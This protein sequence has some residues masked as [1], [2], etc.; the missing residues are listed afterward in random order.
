MSYRDPYAE[1]YGAGSTQYQNQPQRSDSTSDFNPYSTTKQPHQTYD[2]SGEAA[3]YY[4]NNNNGAYRDD[5]PYD[6]VQ[7]HATQKTYRSAAPAHQD[8]YATVVEPPTFGKEAS[9]FDQGE[10]AGNTNRVPGEKFVF[11]LLPPSGWR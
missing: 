9:G 7:R 5:D 6:R 3:S 10:F 1:Q 2:Q 11:A 4:N 8:S